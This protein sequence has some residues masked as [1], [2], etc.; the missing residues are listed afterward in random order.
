MTHLHL[1]DFN[2]PQPRIWSHS[3]QMLYHS[4]FQEHPVGGHPDLPFPQL[5]FQ[6]CQDNLHGFHQPCPRGHYHCNEK[7]AELKMFWWAPQLPK[8]ID[9]YLPTNVMRVHSS[10]I[11]ILISSIHLCI[12]I[13]PF[14]CLFIH[15][16]TLLFLHQTA[17]HL[18]IF[19]S[20]KC[21]HSVSYGLCLG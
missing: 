20:H 7:R 9:H 19:S 15:S 2:S 5:P 13:H 14:I 1:L 4:H 10:I 21:W 3:W 18:L 12:F 17:I 11:H 6:Q 8:R 16:F